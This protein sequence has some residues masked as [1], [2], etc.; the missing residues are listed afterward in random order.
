MCKQSSCYKEG[1]PPAKLYFVNCNGDTLRCNGRPASQE[2]RMLRTKIHKII[3]QKW[4]YNSSRTKVY[5]KI[6]VLLGLNQT[7]THIGYLNK[8]QCIILL[9][10]LEKGFLG[11]TKKEYNRFNKRKIK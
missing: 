10:N 11:I 2:V 7:T 1:D 5:K 9:K 3:D 8:E 4:T 6:G